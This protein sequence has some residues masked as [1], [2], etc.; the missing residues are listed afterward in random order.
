MNKPTSTPLT[1]DEA[2]TEAAR[3]IADAYRP[4]PATL[5]AYRDDSPLPAYGAAP[6]VAQPGTPPMSQRAVD[7]G[8][9]MLTAGLAS[10]PPGLIAIGV[11]IASRHADPTV[12]GMVCAAPAA[13][14]VPILALARLFT[15]VA[16]AVPD[17]HHHH[18]NGP[19]RQEN[20]TTHTRG[21]IARTRNEHHG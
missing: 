13:I 20:T 5:T 11:L 12:I 8:R 4:V 17:E 21:L 18:Y 9:L 16:E 6:P 10:V 19:V 1:E 3:I 14:A 15:R 7:T 2:A